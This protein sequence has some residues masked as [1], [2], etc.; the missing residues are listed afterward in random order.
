MVLTIVTHFDKKIVSYIKQFNVLDHKINGL[1]VDYISN[2]RTLITLRFLSPTEHTIDQSIM[3]TYPARNKEIKATEVKRFLT[4]ILLNF[5][6]YSILLGYIYYSRSTTGTVI[7]GTI[8]MIYQY[9]E[10]VSNSFYNITNTYSQMVQSVANISAVQDI[11]ESYQLV[12]KHQNHYTLN[13]WKSITLNDINFQY[14]HKQI[15]SQ[16][17]FSFKKSEKI[18]FVG[19]S[20]SGKSTLLSLL[21]GLHDASS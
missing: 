7:I 6:L 19:E 8:I 4:S 14:D 21:R 18:A 2:I 3:A 15:F 13:N 1:L 16:L 20:G 12:S 5:L 11:Q 17:T 10:R 9:T